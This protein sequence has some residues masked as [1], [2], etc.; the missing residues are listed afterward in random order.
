LEPRALSLLRVYASVSAETEKA[1]LHSSSAREDAER[2]LENVRR[3]D[4]GLAERLRFEPVELDARRPKAARRK[5]F[6]YGP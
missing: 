5:S 6:L 4:A 3:D 2:F 1:R